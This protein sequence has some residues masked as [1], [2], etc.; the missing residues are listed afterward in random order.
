MG[1]N[2]ISESANVAGK[3]IYDL[4]EPAR[5]VAS[6]TKEKINEAIKEYVKCVISDYIKTM[7]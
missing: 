2:T 6:E 7:E 3:A 5:K 4:L 1:N